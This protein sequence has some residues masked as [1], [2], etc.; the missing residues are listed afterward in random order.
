MLLWIGLDIAKAD[1]NDP[2]YIGCFE[3]SGL[4]AYEYNPEFQGE[5]LSSST[6]TIHPQSVNQ[7]KSYRMVAVIGFIST[8]IPTPLKCTSEY[9]SILAQTVLIQWYFRLLLP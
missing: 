6:F 4:M 5:K 3:G 7:S 9:G 1:D 2:E 8:F